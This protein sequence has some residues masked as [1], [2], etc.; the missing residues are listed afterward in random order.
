MRWCFLVFLLLSVSFFPQAKKSE[1]SEMRI[2]G[3]AE[4]HPEELIDYDVKDANGDVA[5][6]LIIETDLVGLAYDANL[7]MVKMNHSP[8]RDFLFLQY[9]ERE[10]KIMLSG[11]APLQVILKKYGITLEKGKSWLLKLTA[12]KKSELISTVISTTPPGATISIDGENKGQIRTLTLKDGEHDLRIELEGYSPIT[13]KINVTLNNALFEYKLEQKEP[14]AVSIK[15]TPAGAKIY[16]DNA[17]KG[18]TPKTMFL[19]PG[20]YELK[21]SLA[22]YLDASKKIS[23]AE[24]KENAF[25]INLSKNAGTL[26]LTLEPKTATVEINKELQSK[27]DEI[28]LA[29][30]K[31]QVTVSKSGYYPATE[32]VEIK[33]NE[34]I[35]RDIKL[36]EITGT[37][38]LSISPDDAEV[39][40]IKGS[41]RN[42]WKGAKILKGLAVGSYSLS[43]KKAGYKDYSLPVKVEEGKPAIADIN[44]EKAST[45]NVLIEED[46][47]TT[48]EQLAK[49]QR[50]ELFKPRDE[51]ESTSEYNSRTSEAKE[52]TEKYDKSIADKRAKAKQAKIEASK[53]EL[54]GYNIESIG[55]YNPD[56]ETFLLQINGQKGAITVPKSSARSFKEN[57]TSA[58]VKGHSKLNSSLTKEI[59]YSVTVTDP[60]TSAVYEFRQST[61]NMVF[62][63]GGTFQ[64]GSNEGDDEKPIHT[65]TVGDFY[66]GKYEV[67]Q[68]EWEAVMGSNPSNFKGANRPVENVSWNDIKEFLQKLNFKSGKQYRLPTE[69]EW[70]YAARGGNQGQNFKYSGSNSIDEVAWYNGNSSSQTH[71]VGQKQPNELGIYDMSGNVWEWCSDWYDANYYSSSPSKNPQGPS[72]GSS[73]VLRGG[74]WGVNVVCRSSFRD[75]GYPGVRYSSSGFRLAQE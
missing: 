10:L 63:E 69:A 67:T 18:L 4:Y 25:S 32:T 62:V 38:Q 6:G 73:R 5:A 64:M 22:G 51:Y 23:V 60:N 27:T 50:P 15:S 57:Y 52:L 20:E 74:S 24:N 3:M 59:L 36:K 37:L 55:S 31:Y 65:V 49:Q 11:Y 61:G 2:I 26:A 41:Y 66:I 72:S 70:E 48:G 30:G 28:S 1:M 16:I 68:K 53:K 17:E 7:G 14:A 9:K 19:F 13:T 71:E 42:S 45:G 21:L 44:L 46:L 43:A 34:H 47:N 12:D 8:G 33:L 35:L 58:T 75:W 29:P 40:L 39:E 56:D 54:N